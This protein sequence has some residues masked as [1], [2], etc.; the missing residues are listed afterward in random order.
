MSGDV[1][2]LTYTWA[3]RGVEGINRFQIAGIS[4]GLKAGAMASLLPVVRKICRYERPRGRS[5]TLPT[6][7]G[8]FDYR[9]YRFAFCRVGLPPVRGKVG[10]FAAHVLIGP[11]ERLREADIA[12]TFGAEFWWGGL[13][14]EDLAAIDE[15]KRDFT[16]PAL[17]SGGLC[18]TRG[19]R[20][21]LSTES[22]REAAVVLAGS[23]LQLPAKGRLAVHFT[24]DQFGVALRIVASLI[25]EVLDGLSLSTYEGTPVFPFRVMGTAS[26]NPRQLSCS[27]NQPLARSELDDATLRRLFGDGGAA[28]RT[29]ATPARIR[30]ADEYR[31]VFWEAARE[32][33]AVATGSQSDRAVT[34]RVLAVPAAMAYVSSEEAGRATIA[35]AVK[36]NNA[37]A[38]QS[39]ADSISRLS[40]TAVEL[41][42]TALADGYRSSSDLKGCSEAA[43]LTRDPRLR[44][45][46][47]EGAAE[48]A[49]RNGEAAATLGAE[50][51]VAVL[52]VVAARG[53]T[54]EAAACLLL[55][56][57]RHVGT[58]A[59]D[60]RVPDSYLAVMLRQAIASSAPPESIGAAVRERADLMDVAA[61]DHAQLRTAFAVCGGLNGAVLAAVLGAVVPRLPGLDGSEVRSHLERLA[62]IEAAR[63]LLEIARISEA[64]TLPWLPSEAERQAARLLASALAMPNASGLVD[65]TSQVLEQIGTENGEMASS[66]LRRIAYGRTTPSLDLA[67]EALRLSGCPFTPPL[68]ELAVKKA[69]T[70]FRSS[71]EV[72]RAWTAMRESRPSERESDTLVRLLGH[73]RSQR[74]CWS[75]AWLLAWLAG[76]L[77][78]EHPRL[79]G[80]NAELRH[81][82][83]AQA[84][85]EIVANLTNDCWE[86]LDQYVHTCSRRSRA[87]WK[88]VN[89]SPRRRAASTRGLRG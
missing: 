4:P 75:G 31:N 20:T 63:S 68:V 40:T 73:G 16:I 60:E 50:D 78:E 38:R 3:P 56:A 34:Q 5:G 19:M 64:A 54:P 36:Q 9:K 45:M 58:C 6:S 69:A 65:V 11:P 51:A 17:N 12:C 33:V 27:L 48:A 67:E 13:S 61:L 59:R 35:K 70:G 30:D 79:L 39:L 42:F 41:V 26:N 85:R 29:A 72:R 49:L 23:L 43:K 81:A 18:E 80:S 7:F 14:D 66:L 74:D 44:R 83:S 55:S 1:E 86:H 87:W 28:L 47:V 82:D 8:W 52:G 84:A 32:T 2:Q 77:L 76:E 57:A 37:A 21:D 71:E 53:T 88:G 25:P 22:E 15:G 46:V 62:P 89:A 24:D 10:N